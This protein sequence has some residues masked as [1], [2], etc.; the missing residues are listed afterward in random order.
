[1]SAAGRGALALCC[2]AA[3][4]LALAAGARA[5][6]THDPGPAPASTLFEPPAPGT[7]ELP[8]IDVVREHALLGPD[9]KAAP[10]LGLGPGQVALVSFVYRG[11]SDA[12]GCPAALA[13]LRRLDRE[14]AADPALTARTRL[15]TASFDPANDTPERMAELRSHMEPRSD[16]RF[17]TAPDEPALTPVLDDYGQDLVRVVLENGEESGV[18]RHVL[19]V[20]LV[21]ADLAIRN[22]YSAGFLDWRIVLND[23][24]T[25]LAEES[26]D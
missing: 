4:L 3:L 13:L 1:M 17:V 5:H 8:P 22:V 14:I 24:R 10:L 6:E 18:L 11:C 2:V 15:V 26:T 12:K 21:D 16:W 19:K 9:G 25:V 7:Y 20:F 23:I